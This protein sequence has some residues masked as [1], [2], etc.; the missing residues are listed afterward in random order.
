MGPESPRGCRIRRAAL[1][2]VHLRPKPPR[3]GP[4]KT[5]RRRLAAQAQPSL[6]L[7]FFLEI[8]RSSATSQNPKRFKLSAARPVMETRK[9]ERALIWRSMGWEEPR[10]TSLGRNLTLDAGEYRA[11]QAPMG[12]AHAHD[13]APSQGRPAIVQEMVAALVRRHSWWVVGIEPESAISNLSPGLGH[14][15]AVNAPATDVFGHPLL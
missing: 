13:V 7:C 15:E 12:R 14:L 4:H 10:S 2:I 8:L 9:H 1:G 11:V 6:H 3:C 5:E